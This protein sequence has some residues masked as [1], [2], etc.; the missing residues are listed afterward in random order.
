MKQV[1][2]DVQTTYTCDIDGTTTDTVTGT[3][4]PSGWKRAI[5]PVT[6]AQRALGLRS[7]EKHIGPPSLASSD[8]AVLAQIK[9]LLL[10]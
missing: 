9:A 1:V 10:P 7:Q 8:P 5:V 3:A 6:P 2:T 4:L